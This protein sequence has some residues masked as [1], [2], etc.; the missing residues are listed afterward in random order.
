MGFWIFMLSMA[1]LLPISMIV[2]GRSFCKNAPK[3]I[4]PIYGYRTTRSMKNEETW[5]FA[6]NYCGRIWRIAGF[7]LL[8]IS[9]VIM[10][11]VYGKDED[12]VGLY[13]AYVCMLQIVPMIA[14][15]IPTEMALKRN[16]DENGDR[17]K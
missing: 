15:I 5:K 4:N 10:L 12:T 17:R 2:I 6:H 9:V 11:F 16:F 13:G 8:P 14:S 7:I 3:K 1:L